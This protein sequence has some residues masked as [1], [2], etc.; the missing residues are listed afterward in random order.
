[1]RYDADKLALKRPLL[2]I[3][4]SLVAL[5]EEQSA[6]AADA[7]PVGAPASAT[8]ATIAPAGA[9]AG[10]AVAITD[11][12]VLFTTPRFTF[13]IADPT[14]WVLAA[15]LLAFAKNNF[16]DFNGPLAGLVGLKSASCG[17]ST[18]PVESEEAGRDILNKLTNDGEK[19]VTYEAFRELAKQAYK[20]DASDLRSYY[21]GYGDKKLEEALLDESTYAVGMAHGPLFTERGWVLFWVIKRDMENFKKPSEMNAR[22]QDNQNFN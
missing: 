20:G 1:M 12:T 21:Q 3:G 22:E 6:Q 7:A 18:I 17:A 2:S 10:A 9:P 13:D 11:D 5:L 14:T 15:A 4:A 19:E 16:V 8:I